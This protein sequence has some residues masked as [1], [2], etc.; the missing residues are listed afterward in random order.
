MSE[1]VKH[2]KKELELAGLF[3]KDSDYAGMLGESVLSLIKE[4]SSQDH[5]GCSASIAIILFKKLASFKPLTKLTLLDDEWNEVGDN[6]YQN[7]RNSMVFKT[8]KDGKAYYSDAYTLK[9]QKDIC[10]SGSVKLGNGG[11]IREC[12]IKDTGN[13][14]TVVLDVIEKEIKKDYWEMTLKDASQLTEL[15]KFYDFAVV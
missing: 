6:I 14:P 7:N 8:G 2:A 1:L 12:Y 4:F 5:S 3:D 9:T 10:Y 13:M 15:S 11:I